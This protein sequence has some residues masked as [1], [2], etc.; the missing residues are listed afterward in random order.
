MEDADHGLSGIEQLLMG[1]PGANT[2]GGRIAVFGGLGGAF[3][4][5]VKPDMTF[6]PNGSP[7]P[8]IVMDANNPNATLFPYWAYVIVPAVAFGFF[9]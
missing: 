5:F 6:F 4:Y 7:R 3:A 1:I 8:W 2:P 9:I